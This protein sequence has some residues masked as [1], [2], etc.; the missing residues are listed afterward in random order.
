MERFAKTLAA[1]L[2]GALSACCGRGT[3]APVAEPLSI[4]PDTDSAVLYPHALSHPT[5]IGFRITGACPGT[6]LTVRAGLGIEAVLDT[7][8]AEGALTLSL[9]AGGDFAG[10][11]FVDILATDGG[12]SASA[13][14][15]VSIAY[16][17]LK[18]ESL[19]I[20]CEG[21]ERTV[22]VETNILLEVSP[23]PSWL[24]VSLKDGGISLSVLPNASDEPREASVTIGD[25]VL[26][27]VLTV[28]Q[29]GAPVVGI[30]SRERA[31]LHA[32]WEA[33]HM[34][35]NDDWDYTASLPGTRKPWRDEYPV[36]EWAGVT[37]AQSGGVPH[38]AYL[39]V[40]G[41]G[42]LPP[43]IGELRNLLELDV[44]ERNG[45]LSGTIPDSFGNLSMLRHLGMVGTH[46]GGPIPECLAS[47]GN[48]ETLGLEDNWLEGNLPAWLGSMP[49]LVNFGFSGNCLDGQ[50]DPSLT[51]AAWWTAPHGTTGMPLGEYY[52]SLGQRPGHGL[53]L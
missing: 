43:E 20:P 7:D 52:L 14:I 53:W 9:L 48:L 4:V 49:R 42:V 1:L 21:G 36:N 30:P 18:A 26:G 29:D 2:L 35:D 27:K 22:A 34:E 41:H 17:S 11:A 38:V 39:A 28:V 37:L 31:A 23:H 25:G 10:S 45:E 40:G 12:R 3:L 19:G 8:P 15:T 33:L 44:S 13:R 51:K 6:D 32:V 24:S 16:L 50:V 46:V 47:L 5:V